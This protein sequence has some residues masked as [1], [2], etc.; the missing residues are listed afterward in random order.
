M[1]AVSRHR[2]GPRIGRVSSCRDRPRDRDRDRDRRRRDEGTVT[3]FTVLLTTALLACAGLVLDGGLALSARVRAVAVAQEAARAGA[4]QVDL[5]AYRTSGTVALRPDAA[6]AA[7]AAHLAAVGVSGQVSA[8]TDAVTV[9]V[10]TT[11]PTRLLGLIGVT[12]LHVTGHASARP[13]TDAPGSS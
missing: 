1:T 4:Q 12:A 6:I 2:R 9:T 10:T 7:A 5:D 11:Q 13:V 8:T 3:A